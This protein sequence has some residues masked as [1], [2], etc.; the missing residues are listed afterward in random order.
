MSSLNLKISVC[1]VEL[2][3]TRAVCQLSTAKIIICHKSQYLI[4]Q[5]WFCF[6]FSHETTNQLSSSVNLDQQ[7]ADFSWTYSFVYSQMAD[8]LESGWSR[9]DSAWMTWLYCTW[10]SSS[11]RVVRVCYHRKAEEYKRE[12][13]NVSCLE[14][15]TPNWHSIQLAKSSH[16]FKCRFQEWKKRLYLSWKK[17]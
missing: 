9:M 17:L 10:W 11:S 6:C 12:P 16:L 2:K 7:S 4:Q 1:I 13:E 3:C 5:F 14:A 8:G 15:W